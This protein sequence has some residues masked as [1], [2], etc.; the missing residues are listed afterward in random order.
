MVR[1]ISATNTW[2]SQGKIVDQS[3]YCNF[4]EGKGITLIT[5]KENT[6]LL[7][8]TNFIGCYLLFLLT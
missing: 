2:H 3:I 4:I 5:L 8:H 6:Y 1:L 7:R